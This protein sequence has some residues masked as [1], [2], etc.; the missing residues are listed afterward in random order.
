M[1]MLFCSIYAEEIV[2][3]SA[4]QQIVL[5]DDSTWAL[6]TRD[7]SSLQDTSS[8]DTCL[9]CDSLLESHLDKM[10]GKTLIS[11]KKPII[12]SSDGKNGLSIR[13]V[14]IMSKSPLIS[15]TVIGASPCIDEDDEILFL[16]DD[17]TRLE[18]KNSKKFNCDNEAAIYFF[19]ETPELLKLASKK[20][21]SIRVWTVKSYV[22]EDLTDENSNRFYNSLNCILK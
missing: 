6:V 4:G 7:T 2:T 16:F 13:F 8:C 14:K 22:E 12:L 10:T 17:N 11:S 9:T 18:L 21:A 1:L 5:K 3:N 20:V 15:F 19:S